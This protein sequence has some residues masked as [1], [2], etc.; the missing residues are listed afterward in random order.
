MNC[1]NCQQTLPKEAKFCPQCGQEVSLSDEKSAPNNQ[2]NKINKSTQF[3][4]PIHAFA[5]I[6][7][8]V[9]VALIIVF[10]ILD[11]NQQAIKEKKENSTNTSDLPQEIKAQLE[12]LAADPES[13]SLNIEMGN[14]LFDI[15]QFDQAIPFYQK[16]LLKDTL[17]IAVQIDLAVCFFNLRNPEQAIVEM[18]KALKIDPLHPK[19]LFNMGIIY[20]N[21]GKTE[22][23]REFWSR[24]ISVNPELAEAKR[25]QELL[26]ELD[27]N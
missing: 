16:A 27:K 19:A 11:S 24:L 13:I 26:K 6:V 17:N 22:K 3:T 7:S 8:A 1:I 2:D 25:A 15:G 23:V 18:E 20:Y 5:L 10:L 21:L 12:K 14:Q 4:K 9:A